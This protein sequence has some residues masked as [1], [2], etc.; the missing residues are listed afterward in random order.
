MELIDVPEKDETEYK[1]VLV[2][3]TRNGQTALDDV[4]Q[5]NGYENSADTVNR[6]PVAYDMIDNA[7]NRG[8]QVVFRN[9][10]TGQMVELVFDR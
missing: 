4:T 8:L 7:L 3:L 2:G 5:R 10:G 9:P 1:Y 6:A